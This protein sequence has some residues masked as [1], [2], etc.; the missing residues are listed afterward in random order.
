MQTDI[1]TEDIKSIVKHLGNQV[2]IL[3]GKTLLISGGAGFMGSYFLHTLLHL[4]KYK[5]KK[6]CK[7]ICVDNYITGTREQLIGEIRSKN[8]TFIEH[9]VSKPLRLRRKTHYIIHA[10]G[11]ASPVYYRKYPLE[12][13]EVNTRGTKNL[14]ELGR[15]HKVKSFLYF[16]SSEIYGD[17]DP[18]FI[19]TPETYRGNVS[20]IGPR[21]CYDESKRLGEALSINYFHVHNLPVKIVRPFN[22]Y[23]PGM[24]PQD[25]R[26]IPTFLYSGLTNKP[27]TVHDTGKQTRTYCYITDAIV[28]FFLVLLS[29]KNGEVYN[30]GND[31]PEITTLE[32]AR[33]VAKTLPEKATI[34]RIPYPSNYPQDVPNRRCPDLTK[35]KRTLGYKPEIDLERG[36]SR[37]LVWYQERYKL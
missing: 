35:I 37:L 33:I 11:I 26:V 25:Y 18:K 34:T 8:I 14:L 21:A 20:S 4:N 27:L 28:A 10:A 9:D 16:S 29:D 22:V 32:L 19:P 1:V 12:A 3:S 2:D 31:K 15:K 17:P 30:V 13:I 6:P 7:V 24:K 23:G 36:L 5:F